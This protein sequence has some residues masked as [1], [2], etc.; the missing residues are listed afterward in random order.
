[1]TLQTITNL[2]IIFGVVIDASTLI[3]G[4]F[5]YK[6]QWDL[7]MA[8]YLFSMRNKFQKNERF[9]TLLKM[10]EINSKELLDNTLF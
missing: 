3:L 5:E 10:L 6:R 7:K 1:M 9:V 2:S 8:E 4:I